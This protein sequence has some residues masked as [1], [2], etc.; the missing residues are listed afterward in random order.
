MMILPIFIPVSATN[1][2]MD[3]PFQ[4]KHGAVNA[5]LCVLTVVASIVMAGFLRA[6]RREAFMHELWEGYPSEQGPL[7]L[8]GTFSTG[9]LWEL[10]VGF[11]I[12]LLATLVLIVTLMFVRKIWATIA[13]SAYIAFAVLVVILGTISAL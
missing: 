11:F 4:Q 10:S 8:L 13:G 3:A 6:A 7:S 1:E 2:P 9:D 12:L 5:I